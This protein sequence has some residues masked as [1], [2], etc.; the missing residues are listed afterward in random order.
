M[1]LHR[2]PI[3]YLSECIRYL[4]ECRWGQR[5]NCWWQVTPYTAGLQACGGALA[6]ALASRLDMFMGRGAGTSPAGGPATE[7]GCEW[8]GDAAKNGERHQLEEPKS[9]P[10]ITPW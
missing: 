3:R 8:V 1:S 2:E 7:A 4:S 6:L 5:I 9:K 10:L